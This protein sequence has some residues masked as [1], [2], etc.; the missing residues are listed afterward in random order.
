MAIRNKRLAPKIKYVMLAA[1]DVDVDVFRRQISE[2][3]VDRPPFTIFVSKDDT[4]LSASRR[5][6]GDRPRLGG[7]DPNKEPYRT[8]FKQANI[9]VV[10]LT[11]IATDDRLGHS[12]FAGKSG[13]RPV[14]R[15]AYRA[16]P[17]L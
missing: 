15:H 2:M 10:D 13:Y 7:V 9:N 14:D 16:R 4:A 17:G 5:I 8:L 11:G 6:W 3:G 1:P 12:T